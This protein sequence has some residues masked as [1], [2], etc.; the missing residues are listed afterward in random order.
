MR[1]LIGILVVIAIFVVGL[2]FYRGW[3]TLSSSN[4]EADA[5]KVSVD[6]TVDRGKMKEDAKSVKEKTKELT[7]KAKETASQSGK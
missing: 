4:P 7:N 2:G 5:D 6:V 3:F 1:K